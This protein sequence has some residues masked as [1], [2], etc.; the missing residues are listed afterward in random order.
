MGYLSDLF[1]SAPEVPQT[2][3]KAPTTP[4]PTT[5]KEEISHNVNEA[6]LGNPGNSL[7]M[8]QI[9]AT[10]TLNR[11][12]VRVLF[13]DAEFKR[14]YHIYKPEELLIEDE[15]PIAK[16]KIPYNFFEMVI[17]KTSANLQI[18]SLTEMSLGFSMAYISLSSYSLQSFAIKKGGQLLDDSAIYASV[19]RVFSMGSLEPPNFLSEESSLNQN[20]FHFCRQKILEIRKGKD[21]KVE[22]GSEVLGLAKIEANCR[23]KA[24]EGNF[25][26]VKKEG[27]VQRP[28][29]ICLSIYEKGYT[30]SLNPVETNMMSYG[31]IK[32][33]LSG[34]FL[35]FSFEIPLYLD[36]ILNPSYG[37]LLSNVKIQEKYANIKRLYVYSKLGGVEGAL[38]QSELKAMFALSHQAKQAND[39]PEQKNQCINQAAQLKTFILKDLEVDI[40]FVRVKLFML[41]ESN[42]LLNYI[43]DTEIDLCQAALRRYSSKTPTAA[44]SSTYIKPDPLINAQICRCMDLYKIYSN[45]SAQG[46]AP[47]AGSAVPLNSVYGGM[48]YYGKEEKGRGLV[49]AYYK[50]NLV[51]VDIGPISV[52]ASEIYTIAAN[53]VIIP[54]AMI[55]RFN[56]KSLIAGISQDGECI[57][58]GKLEFNND[59][60]TIEIVL[61]DKITESNKIIV[62][63]FIED[64]DKEDA[65]EKEEKEEKSLKKIIPDSEGISR[66][67]EDIID[68]ID[69][70]ENHQFNPFVKQDAGALQFNEREKEVRKR[71]LVVRN[72]Y[73]HLFFFLISAF[74]SK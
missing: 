52:Q 53:N 10:A 41:D 15:I 69:P 58:I 63:D 44:Q 3:I 29:K 35:E 20:R 11:L 64:P 45:A 55:F 42:P 36:K 22:P 9:Q 16:W 40:P 4:V 67:V 37:M 46:N 27:K 26:V 43:K 38:M 70:N 1:V 2:P 66:A 30:G 5:K 39:K 61:R 12:T 33:V 65:G 8:I 72:F 24:I 48:S 68:I 73:T 51:M 13:D 17:V 18:P 56:I 31:S 47:G 6:T 34:I 59:I 14:Y 21:E 32:M 74:L 71:A 54:Q 19:H 49:M 25:N 57:N 62:S 50:P 60:T 23:E 7:S 28:E